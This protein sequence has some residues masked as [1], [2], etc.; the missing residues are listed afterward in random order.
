MENI[1]SQPV[2]FNSSL[3]TTE[4]KSSSSKGTIHFTTDE[5]I[6]LNGAD[7]TGVK[8]VEE[9]T[10]NGKI[11]VDGTDVAVHGLGTAAYTAST[12]YVQTIQIGGT[13]QTKT[14][15]IVNLPAY[16]T[17]LPASDVSAWA[18]KSALDAADV[19]T[20][21]AS[22]VGL[23]NVTNDAQVKRTEMGAANGVATLDTNGKVPSS[24]LPSY[25]DDV[26][27]AASLAALPTTGETGKIYVTTDTNKTYRW[28]GT[29]YTEI[30]ASLALGTTT[31]TALDG[32]VGTDHIANTTVHITSNE[33]TAWN[34]KYA[35]PSTGI[36][37]TDLASAVQT[38]ITNGATA[39][40]WG[41]HAQAGYIK[42]TDLADW[43][44][45]NEK[46]TYNATE[47]SLN[48]YSIATTAAAVGANDTVQTAISKLEK[49]I[50][51][52]SS[53]VGTVT[54]VGLSAP[55]GL[56]AS[57]TPV[58]ASGTLALSWASGYEAMAT[59]DKTKWNQ[60]VADIAEMDE[61]VSEALNA[62]NGSAGFSE[63]GVYVAL[64]EGP[65]ANATSLADAISLLNTAV[66]ASNQALVWD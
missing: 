36:P 64:T 20:L 31:G 37:A 14:N 57:G 48:N 46:P 6:I 44:K 18:K 56:S 47:V 27:E 61:V 50:A 35:K 43:A 28:S 16:P 41:N 26:I 38:N 15:G 1:K 4:A 39:Y 30:S 22:K 7:F 29:Q 66:N 2:K 62:I 21:E 63:N 12:N 13:A 9:S 34:G 19:P 10:A 58:T 32:K 17:T 8:K 54:S 45:A 52:K 59:T 65:A 42:D 55:T 40:G 5:R 51:A 33:R 23:G 3:N 49:Q 60:A 11:K 53:T 24:Q 25:V